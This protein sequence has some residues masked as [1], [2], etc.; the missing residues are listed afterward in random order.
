MK[1]AYFVL[2][3]AILILFI[4]F[5]RH[6]TFGKVEY[7]PILPEPSVDKS[8]K[9][10][11]LSAF[12]KLPLHFVTN[13]GQYPEAV[14]YYAKS[15]GA[16]VYCTE[17]GLVFGF[18]EG[19][20]SLKFSENRRVKP[21]PRNELEGKVNYFIGNTPTQWYTDISTFS[22]VL[23]REV[24]PGIDLVYSGSQRRLKYTFYLKPGANPNQ[25]QMIYEDIE[26]VSVDD[27][28]G[29]LVIPTE[30]GE[31]RDAV[32]VAHQDIDGIRKE[33]DISF[34]L[35]GEKSVG[36]AV[37]DY[38]SNLMLVIDPGYST[39]LGG[40]RGEKGFDIAV[41]SSGNTYV[42]GFTTSIDFPTQNPFQDNNGSSSGY[43]DVFIAKLSSSGN[44]LIYST[45][46]GGSGWDEGKGIAVDSDGNAYVTGETSESSDF[47][48][49]NPYQSIKGE[50][51]DAFV[52]KLN[53]S[54]NTLI[55]STYL[56]GN[57][58]DVTESIA[59]D[60]AG[61]AY[62]TG[63]TNSSD[64]PIKN[65]YQDSNAG[66]NDAFF[67][68]F[69]SSGDTLIYSTYLGGSSGDEG[70][71]IAVDSAGNAYITGD[72]DSPDFPT[73]NPYQDSHSEVG[74]DSFVTKLESNGNTLVYSTFLSAFGDT[75]AFDIAVDSSENAYVTGYT[76]ASDFP[77]Q[78]PYQD[79][80]AGSNDA[81]VT[82]FSNSGNT[83]IY[84]TYLGGNGS[85]VA[86]SIAVDGSGN[87]YLTG[88]TTSLDFPIQNPYQSNHGG[89]DY[90][91]FV[92]K[93][94]SY[95]DTLNYS[96][97]L[98][99]SDSDSGWG[100][101]VNSL[102][103]AFLT[104][105][106]R[107][108]NFP[109]HNSY[110]E[111]LGGGGLDAFVASFLS[112]GSLP[113]E[114]SLLTASASADGVTIRWRTETEVNNIGFSIYRSE[115]KDSN[116]TKI[117]FVSG[118]G[119]SAMPTD[120][121]FADKK[122]EQGKTYFYYIEDIDIAGVR[123]KSDIIKVVV[124]PAQPVPKEFQLLQ[125][126]PNPFNPETW[127]PF[128]LAQN[129]PV[130][131]SIYN[132]KGQLIRTISLGNRNAGIYTT[133]DKAVYWDGRSNTGEKVSSGAYY[134]T[135]QAGEFRATRKMVIVK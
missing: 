68:K 1:A 130:S 66:S 33:V 92:T 93:L 6:N 128:K 129:K 70:Y 11:V 50:G 87:A 43:Y 3:L 24:Y 30:W 23:Y 106:T 52:T 12:G 114:L 47:P 37:G 21:E 101:T 134:Y 88:Y 54:G 58:S 20:I 82:K 102:G 125:N 78:N 132:T 44:T 75:R 109:T 118:A 69:S 71:G 60:S 28:T 25:I 76:V 36:F 133:K 8:T 90:D 105:Y 123:N 104:G 39:Y 14:V 113:V 31:M 49:E 59:V 67:T 10:A 5:G 94:S 27:A 42:T 51:H 116:Y 53:S 120:Y 57:G 9:S 15:E 91:A 64:F 131:I 38:D 63:Y 19:H 98:G 80:N 77:T 26:S 56:G 121:Q 95:G 74:A 4:G 55:Y 112:D 22:E 108:F 96:T 62:V 32:P 97:F 89:G 83:L 99:G 16:T 85:D 48:L 100:I 86:E 119:N 122:A 103:D 18:D 81:F 117:T 127:I 29:E 73:Q 110:Q 35:V 126:Y 107:S 45:Y 17:E 40:S 115:T 79:S 72:T 46:L 34:C 41:D 65:P 135:L 7:M 2:A 13:Q 124:P 84:S 111:S 61:N